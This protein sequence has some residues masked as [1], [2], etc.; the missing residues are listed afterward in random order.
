M[1]NFWQAPTNDY[2]LSR[3]E[4]R[5]NV[6]DA[7]K[8]VTFSE[9]GKMIN[10]HQSRESEVLVLILSPEGFFLKYHQRV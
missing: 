3:T 7:L 1:S 2:L 9:R 10:L 8:L 4:K 6:S 5:I